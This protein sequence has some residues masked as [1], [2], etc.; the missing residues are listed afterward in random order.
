MSS[1][2]G[3]EEVVTHE[4]L[5]RATKKIEGRIA[6]QLSPFFGPNRLMTTI[7]GDTVSAYRA[8]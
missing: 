6:K 5:G 3:G 2:W 7:T 1:W 4:A 8:H